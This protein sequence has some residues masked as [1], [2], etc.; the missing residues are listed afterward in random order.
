M[1]QLLPKVSSEQCTTPIPVSLDCNQSNQVL[2]DM[3]D[4]DPFKESVELQACNDATVAQLSVEREDAMDTVSSASYRAIPTSLSLERQSGT[5]YGDEDIED[6]DMD[7]DHEL[8]KETQV[9]LPAMEIVIRNLGILQERQ[10]AQANAHLKPA[11]ERG[12][13]STDTQD[14][15]YS[16]GPPIDTQLYNSSLNNL[17]KSIKN[18]PV[19]RLGPREQEEAG[20]CM[21]FQN[22]LGAAAHLFGCIDEPVRKGMKYMFDNNFLKAKSLFQKRCYR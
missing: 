10:K 11:Q 16:L 3:G 13:N 8:P 20:K 19:N 21:P 18:I 14:I 6:I 17:D 4:I 2:F 1:N 22:V 12:I 5:D 7:Y 15:E 9:H